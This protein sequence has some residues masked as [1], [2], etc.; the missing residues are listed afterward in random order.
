LNIGIVKYRYEHY[1]TARNIVGVVPEAEY[2]KVNDNI[3][4]L[5]WAA[6]RINRMAGRE[7]ISIFDSNNQFNDLGLNKVDVIHFFNGISYA[8]TPWVSTFETILPRF[9]SVVQRSHGEKPDFKDSKE[10]RKVRK[11]FEALAGPDC[12]KLIAMSKCSANFQKDLLD[13]FAD[14]RERIEEK[15]V[16][17]QP[18]QP[19]LVSQFEDKSVTLR[20]KVK[21]MFVGSAFFRKGGMEIVETLGRLRETCGYDIELTLVSSFKIE[22]YATR[23]TPL[24]V[25]R[26]KKLV[27]ENVDWIR[28]FPQL[29]NRDVIDLMKVSHIGLLP[30]YADTYGYSVL[31]FQATGCP[32][33]STDVRALPEMNNNDLGWLIEVPKNRLGEAIYTTP[34][35]RQEIHESIS[36][37]LEAAVHAIFADPEMIRAKSNKAIANIRKNYNS[38]DRAARLREIYLEA[39]HG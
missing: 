38:E 28:H 29:P 20:G 21:F 11:A 37:G 17:I 34:A 2:I 18:P 31:E 5:N 30:T 4:G 3:A 27:S 13:H 22:N 16:V 23:E 33:I 26:A 1:S 39:I 7:L 9:R 36:A 32:V 10:E 12:K 8:H 35:N 14:Y 25:E 19:V 15:L 24:D 6:R